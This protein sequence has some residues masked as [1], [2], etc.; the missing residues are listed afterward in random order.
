V[1]GSAH[2]IRSHSSSVDETKIPELRIEKAEQ[3]R[4][5]EQ[6]YAE[7]ETISFLLK[8]H[9]Y[10][11]YWLDRLL[12]LGQMREPLERMRLS[13][14]Q[15]LSLLDSFALLPVECTRSFSADHMMQ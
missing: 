10:S 8:A 3:M 2:R 1:R 6:L 4:F 7:N 13:F 11:E 9:L 15:K 14:A 12:A 5:V